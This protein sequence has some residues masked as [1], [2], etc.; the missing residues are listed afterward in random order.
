MKDEDIELT[1]HDSNILDTLMPNLK[2]PKEHKYI[3]TEATQFEVKAITLV[4]QGDLQKAIDL[5]SEAILKFPN[6]PSLYNNRAQIYR[7]SKKDDLALADL[8]KAKPLPLYPYV[9]CKINEQLGWLLFKKGETENAQKCFERAAELGSEDAKR[10]SVRCNPY[11]ELCN[12]MFREALSGSNLL[13][14]R[15]KN[16]K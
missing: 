2:R 4:E 3:P 14:S 5:L 7:L 6:N 16:D 11:A 9:E 13:F 15:E 1:E 8:L 12:A 10:M